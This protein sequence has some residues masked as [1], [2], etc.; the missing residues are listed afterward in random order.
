[1]EPLP[2]VDQLVDETR[3]ARF[4]TE[5]DLA[6]AYMQF[7]IMIRDEDQYKA[8]LRSMHS[9]FG[10]VALSFDWSGRA[11]PAVGP[12]VCAGV[13]RHHTHLLQTREE[14]LVHVCTIL[15]TLR[16][17]KLYAEASKF[18]FSRSSVGFLGHV[19]SLT[20][21]SPLRNGRR[22]R[23]VRT[24]TASLA[25][26]SRRQLLPQVCLTL[27]RHCSPAHCPLKPPG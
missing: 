19:I 3:G 14:H 17:R 6:M 12:P 9:I 24:C 8:S 13:L 16:H 26:P 5:L 20:I 25:S 1:M 23:R 15:E 18:Q 27:L 10:R 7:R 21:S 2:H 22:R 11:Q 4:V